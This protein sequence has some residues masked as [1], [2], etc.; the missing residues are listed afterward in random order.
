[1]VRDFNPLWGG[2]AMFCGVNGSGFGSVSGYR[3][4]TVSASVTAPWCPCPGCRLSVSAHN[5]PRDD[6]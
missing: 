1:M 6:A 3:L 5:A 2:F 4:M